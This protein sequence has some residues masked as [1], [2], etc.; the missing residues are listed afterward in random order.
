M[1]EVSTPHTKGHPMSDTKTPLTDKLLKE[2][3]AD[4][5]LDFETLGNHARTLE[6]ENTRLRESYEQHVG[7]LR[8]CSEENTQLRKRI[9]ELEAMLETYG[10]R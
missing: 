7:A 6:A 2:F 10:H 5:D 1:S 9:N 4:D 8:L 3:Q